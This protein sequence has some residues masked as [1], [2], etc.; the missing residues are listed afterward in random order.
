[1]TIQ[2]DALM[3][4]VFLSISAVVLYFTIKLFLY[5]G[6]DVDELREKQ[7]ELYMIMQ[8]CNQRYEELKA[9]VHSLEEVFGS[10]DLL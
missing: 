10:K 7:K 1:M 3:F 4:Y 6:K 2:V 5:P 9:R 8:E